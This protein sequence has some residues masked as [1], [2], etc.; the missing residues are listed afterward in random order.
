MI[1]Q[2]IYTAVFPK[3]LFSIQEHLLSCTQ[4]VLITEFYCKRPLYV[5]CTDGTVEFTLKDQFPVS[6]PFF[7][8][9]AGDFN[10]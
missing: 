6:R 2:V 3:Y 10:M 4:V 9:L 5:I 7:V 8:V 1:S